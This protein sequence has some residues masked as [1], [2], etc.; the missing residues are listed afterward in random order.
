M[1]QK[2]S[3]KLNWERLCAEQG[4]NERSKNTILENFLEESGM[5]ANFLK[6][7]EDVANTEN[8]ESW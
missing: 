8:C 4:W 7:A 2:I 5:M 6:Y 1:K 3:D